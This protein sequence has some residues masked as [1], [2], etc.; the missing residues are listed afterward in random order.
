MLEFFQQLGD[1]F[2]QPD[3]RM[4]LFAV[5]INPTPEK[6]AEYISPDMNSV[7]VPRYS[8]SLAASLTLVS[9]FGRS[10]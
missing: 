7:P 9:M 10:R 3:L 8:A 1:T 5:G 4:C 2:W 6:P